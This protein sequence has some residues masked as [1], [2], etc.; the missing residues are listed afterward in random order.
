MDKIFGQAG[1]DRAD[2]LDFDSL[3]SIDGGTHV[4]GDSCS[5]DEAIL[6]NFADSA[7]VNRES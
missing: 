4:S 2:S 5:R 6:T 3:D 7:V 1:D